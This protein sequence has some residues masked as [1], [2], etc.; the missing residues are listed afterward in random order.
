MKDSST[1]SLI[2]LRYIDVPN[3][4]VLNIWMAMFMKCLCM[5]ELEWC[6]MVLKSPLYSDCGIVLILRR[7]S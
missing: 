5:C 7:I 6:G 3:V 1:K 2:L 4:F